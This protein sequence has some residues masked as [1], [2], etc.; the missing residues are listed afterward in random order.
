MVLCVSDAANAEGEKGAM[1]FRWQRKPLGMSID[2]GGRGGR[3]GDEGLARTRGGYLRKTWRNR[4]KNEVRPGAWHHRFC[5]G[6]N[7]VLGATAIYPILMWFRIF[8]RAPLH[9]CTVAVAAVVWTIYIAAVTKYSE[10]EELDPARRR[11]VGMLVGGI[12]Y[13]QLV[14]LIVLT[15]ASP[16]PETLR[17]LLVAGAVL[18]VLLRAFRSAWPKVSAS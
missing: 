18:L 10:G 14:A 17:P 15:L 9:V 11:R 7:V 12:V 13:L 1:K 4:G 6:I 5:R 16:R 2:C 3:G 8:L